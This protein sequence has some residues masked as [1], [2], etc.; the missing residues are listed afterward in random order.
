MSLTQVLEVLGKEHIPG[1]ETVEAS[2]RQALE[3][4]T[5][6]RTEAI[7]SIRHIQTK[8]STE[9][10]LAAARLLTGPS[11]GRAAGEYISG[12]INSANSLV[13]PL[14]DQR[15]APETAL[16]LARGMAE[17]EPLIDARLMRKM[18]ENADGDIAA[19]PTEVALRVLWLLDKFSD[20][21]RVTLYLMQLARHPS[22]E[23]RSKA[24]LLLGRGNLN[25][26]R[27]K[28][29][30]GSDDGR[31]RANAV[32][33]LWGLNS[34]QARQMF[35]EAASDSNRRVAVNALVGLCK[36]GE[37]PARLKLIELS[38]SQDPVMKR[39]AAWAMGQVG[40]PEFAPTLDALAQTGDE[41]LRNMAAR[42][43]Q[44]LHM[45]QPEPRRWA[46]RAS[47]AGPSVPKIGL[48]KPTEAAPDLHSYPS[49]PSGEGEVNPSERGEADTIRDLQSYPLASSSRPG[50]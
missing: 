13:D 18:L 32:E 41:E 20:C 27:V 11:T 8:D 22:A 28:Q 25:L 10:V 47:E 29:F 21:S 46:A 42:S 3:G 9:F 48:L 12:L 6:N 4:F 24:A 50:R 26:M 14:L 5:D 33:S 7:N 35:R 40:D 30:L 37:K 45:P 19:I 36:A 23:V 31:M 15:A 39:A 43:L 1:D 16:S 44:M 2:L 34:P 17:A 38:A 49:R